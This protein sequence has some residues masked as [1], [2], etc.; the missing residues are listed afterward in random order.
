MAYAATAS[1]T[2]MFAGEFGALYPTLQSCSALDAYSYTFHPQ[3]ISLNIY[4][5]DVG[6]LLQS[7]GCATSFLNKVGTRIEL[8]STVLAGDATANGTLSVAITL[9]NAGYGRVIR[10][11][12]ATL[13]LISN[14]SV[15]AQI[16]IPLANLDLRQL[17][18]S[19]TPAPRTFQFNVTLPQ[20][21]P[22]GSISAALLIPDP[23]PSLTLQPAY[24]LPFNSVD[25]DNVPVFDH[26][27]GYN[28]IA[29]FTEGSTNQKRILPI[30]A[31][32]PTV[33]GA[34]SPH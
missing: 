4:P 9:L 3:S 8:Q 19:P 11:R 26:T 24:A 13:I 14:G 30:A 16:P 5:P 33:R 34:S 31:P 15:F 18:S 28:L 29:T 7:E 23:A 21:L 2:S 27:T 22:F 10:P 6:A 12:P 32:L 1:T 17:A 20:S 25:Q